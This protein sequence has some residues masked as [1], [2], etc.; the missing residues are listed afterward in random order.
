MQGYWGAVRAWV[1]YVRAAG[2]QSQS[3]KFK[4]WLCPLLNVPTYTVSFCL[5]EPV[6]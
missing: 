6:G 4:S 3:C 1:L 5:Q 2:P